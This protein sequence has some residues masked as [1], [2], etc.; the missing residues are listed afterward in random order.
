MLNWSLTAIDRAD[1]C[2]SGSLRSDGALHLGIAFEERRIGRRLRN[3]DIVRRYQHTSG[4]VAMSASGAV[5]L[6]GG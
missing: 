6:L 4:R 2:F 3:D 1:F 5:R